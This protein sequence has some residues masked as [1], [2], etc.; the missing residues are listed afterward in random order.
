MEDAVPIQML[1]SY[2]GVIDRLS[3]SLSHLTTISLRP[4]TGIMV[5]RLQTTI[6]PVFILLYKRS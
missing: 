2:P 3:K 5:L 4:M 6:A 1:T